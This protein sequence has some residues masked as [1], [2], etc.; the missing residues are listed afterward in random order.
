MNRIVQIIGYV[1]GAVLLFVYFRYFFEW[2]DTVDI[3]SQARVGLVALALLAYLAGVWI[4]AVRWTI[5][6]R[7]HQSLSWQQGYHAMMTS[8]LASFAFPVRIG[9][10]LK[11][12]ILKKISN[13][14]YASSTAASIID[15]MT[16]F[17]IIS[18]VMCFTPLAGFQF[19]GWSEKLLPFLGVMLVASAFTLLFGIRFMG[20]LKSVIRWA[21]GRYGM[22]EARVEGV[23]SNRFFDYAES[24][25]Q[26]CHISA[27][28]S[29]HF[30]MVLLLG[31]VTL[32]LD[33]LANY[34]LM[35]A[36]S[37]NIT[38]LQ[39]TIAACFFNLLFLVPSPPGQVGTAEV[40]P[41]L[42]FS[43]GLGLPTGVVASTA[44]LWHVLTAIVIVV[45]GV[46]SFYTIGF[47]VSSV[48]GLAQ[49]KLKYVEE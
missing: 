14:S 44:I 23:M 35:N 13:T 18:L 21:L 9:E 31:F 17:L 37:Q 30:M 38:F 45:L 4:R 29:V 33:G 47:H 34:F 26:Q 10:V 42:V 11:L 1:V 15:R 25:V 20:R 32:S 3:L 16:S 36:F 8:N 27:Y 49:Q 40:F 41:V 22:S 6:V 24:T 2:K 46:A 5:L 48:M 39:A 43:M 28:S 12:V 19:P 7:S